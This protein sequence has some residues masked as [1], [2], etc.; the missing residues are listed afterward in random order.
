VQSRS[1]ASLRA[2]S[3]HFELKCDVVLIDAL[4]PLEYLGDV[5]S[6][7]SDK[8]YRRIVIVFP[9]AWQ[10]QTEIFLR[11]QTF[12]RDQ[13]VDLMR[14]R[15]GTPH[16]PAAQQMTC[17]ILFFYQAKSLTSDVN[18]WSKFY[19]RVTW[20]EYASPGRCI[21]SFTFGTTTHCH[22]FSGAQAT[23]HPWGECQDP[24]ADFFLCETLLDDSLM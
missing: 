15:H 12:C 21:T 7:W 5:R 3:T 14:C 11:Y 18:R 1:P 24:R 2:P 4:N 22:I 6:A 8:V 13:Q 16:I 19:L 23:R 10:F 17:P 9:S 20:S